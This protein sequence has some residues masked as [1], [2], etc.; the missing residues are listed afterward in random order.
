M[1]DLKFEI[2]LFY[3]DRPAIVQ[4]FALPSV[5]NSE[6]SNWELTIIDDSSCQGA[7]KVME[8]FFSNNPKYVSQSSKVKIIKTGDTL[9]T[10]A[11]RG[12]ES[13]FGMFANIALE[14]HSDA[15]IC[16]MLCDDDGLTPH[17]LSH[18]N[19]FYQENPDKI[20]SYCHVCRF[21]PLEIESFDDIEIELSD[22]YINKTHDIENAYCEVDASQ[23]SWRRKNFI[24]DRVKFPYPRTVAVDAALFLSMYEKWGHKTQCVF[25]GTIGQ[26]KGVFSDQLGCREVRFVTADGS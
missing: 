9:E 20:Y 26:Y 14:K 21:N 5:F 24:E 4:K 11:A 13:I 23:V 1:S 25:N 18:L 16:L 8:E 15:D 2:L 19:K 7:E 3:Y 6:H 10:K 22:D 17:Y 12:W